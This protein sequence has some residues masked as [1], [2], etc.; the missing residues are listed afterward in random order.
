MSRLGREE[1]AVQQLELLRSGHESV[2]DA[3]TPSAADAN[4]TMLS[5]A[6]KPSMCRKS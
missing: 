4:S 2:Q 1:A 6:L 3:A 5:T